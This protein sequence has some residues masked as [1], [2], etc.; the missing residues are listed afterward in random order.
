MTTRRLRDVA[1]AA[2]GLLLAV[3]PRAAAHAQQVPAEE[4]IVE[5]VAQRLPTLTVIV[6]VDSAGAL[7]LPSREVARH[8]G[9]APE[10]RDGVLT[11]PRLGGGVARLD[12]RSRELVIGRDTL[13]LTPA[14]LI[15]AGDE[16]Y[17]RAQR[18]A[19]M[20]EADLSFNP[21]TLTVS[22][23]RTAPFPAQQ[24]IL[25]EQRRA[26][27]LA[28]SQRPSAAWDAVRYRPVTGGAIVDWQLTT[29]DM[30]PF[31]LTTL[32]TRAGMAL[33]G[34][35]LSVGSTAE[36]G[37]EPRELI[38]DVDVQ[39]QRF[40][41]HGGAVRMVRAGDLATSGLFA[42]YLRGV[43]VSNRPYMRDVQYGEVVL[44][45][46]LPA[47]WDYEVF[48]GSQLLGYSEPGARDGIAVPLRGGTTPVQVRLFGPAGEE[49]IST[50]LYQL[51]MTMLRPGT[52]EYV[53]G[54]GTCEGSPCDRFAHGD[55]RFGASSFITL[56]GGVEYVADSTGTTLRPYALTSFTT[57][58][59]MIGE[60]QLMP[61]ALT[62]ALLTFFP[63]EGTTAWLRG[64]L[65]RPG[66]GPISLV[67]DDGSR[68]DAELTLEE[69]ATSRAAQRALGS[70]RVGVGAGG[71]V[72]TGLERW[73]ASL[74]G[75]F[76]SGRAEARYD[77]QR[78]AAEPHMVS[79][80][81]ILLSPLGIGRT[82]YRP[83]L[84]TTVGGDR[85][86]FRL[87]EMGV[88]V[89][90]GAASQL[91][92]SVQWS[93][94]SRDPAFAISWTMRTGGVQSFVR[95]AGG[96]SGGASSAA[97]V[98]GS[99]AF[100]HDGVLMGQSAARSGY[101]GVH[102]LVFFDNDGDG[103]F[104][105]GDEPLPFA[106]VTVGG[107]PVTA[108]VGGRFHAWNLHPYN[109]VTVAV[110]S[111]RIEDPSWTVAGGTLVLRPAPNTSRRID[112]PLVRTRELVGSIV[113]DSGVTTVASL[114]LVITDLATAETVNVVTFSD[115]Q[116]YLSR[117]R[118]GRYSITVAASSLELVNAT[119][120]PPVIEFSV[121]AQGDDPVVEL[122]PILLRSR[123]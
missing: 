67:P 11:L 93:R 7:L 43:E 56:G 58:Q 89:H 102:G 5:V 100:A 116:Y 63:R 68:W 52:F 23:N 115:G 38:Q 119:P 80:T 2:C 18:L 77:Y 86:G 65:S 85:L 32:R 40:F 51:P 105:D 28:G 14:E 62:S 48:Q 26:V 15:V 10:L 74:G 19:A 83:L 96:R 42:R 35:D 111:A 75:A 81:T 84:Q 95:A 72:D 55:V 92:T 91:T 118:P 76:R 47:G 16:V 49:V 54:G 88:T 61:G 107:T 104:S 20:V 114:T 41:P 101:A 121:S 82:S 12:T 50:L 113:G 87:A 122:P 98:S 117:L 123:R 59:R 60:V 53:V 9:F 108:D 112:V 71:R 13:R 73:R 31:R 46:E 57:G 22:L 4:G 69:R 3:L 94:G 37:R 109:P 64:S 106:S 90:P 103:V 45:P 70:L 21:A 17:L 120:Y 33:A 39:Y 34:G 8:L 36:L 99:A 24:R 97:M 6:Y 79:A 25:A 44:R 27:M 110:D 30:D 78:Y 29:T 66:F 1:L